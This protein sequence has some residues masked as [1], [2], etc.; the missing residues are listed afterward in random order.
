MK[1]MAY[2]ILYDYLKFL[3]ATDYTRYVEEHHPLRCPNHI[4]IKIRFDG[5]GNGR[6]N[7]RGIPR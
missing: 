7:S 4:H 3:A 6:E 1:M 2:E 5:S